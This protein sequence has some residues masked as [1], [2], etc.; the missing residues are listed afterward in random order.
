[1]SDDVLLLSF[2]EL[3]PSSR[4]G[5]V[6]GLR[7]LD[8][9]LAKEADA[10]LFYR[11]A[12]LPL[13]ADSARL[14]LAQATGYAGMFDPG[15]LKAAEAAARM[16]EQARRHG[17][18]T[19]IIID[20]LLAMERGAAPQAAPAPGGPA[21]QGADKSLLRAQSV[22]LLAWERERG[23][24]EAGE[25]G[26]D[27]EGVLARFGQSLGLEPDDM[28]DLATSGL[29]LPGGDTPYAVAED[30]LPLLGAVLRLVPEAAVL[31]VDAPSVAAFWAEAGLPLAPAGVD[32]LGELAPGLEPGPWQ[33]L[34]CTG[35]AL[36]GQSRPE[37][38][39]P[40][41]AAERTVLVLAPGDGEGA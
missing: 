39:A 36:L 37:K 41:L 34:R 25:V 20:E 40:W 29:S 23:L 5:A 31:C 10:D 33:V 11:P 7:F 13:D 22:L 9:G 18:P 15:A 19:R 2:P 3:L 24:A 14:W 4:R 28:D 6:P 27:Y 12:A 26:Q 32:E 35:H 1:M 21:E 17:D 8:P 38:D 16:D 30:W